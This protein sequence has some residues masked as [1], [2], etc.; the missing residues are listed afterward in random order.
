M[1]SSTANKPLRQYLISLIAVVNID[2]SKVT[3]ESQVKSGVDSTGVIPKNKSK[4]KLNKRLKKLSSQLSK[5]FNV[6][7][8]M[9]NQLSKLNKMANSGSKQQI[10]IR[11]MQAQIK[12][13]ETQLT[14]LN[15]EIAGF[16]T[17]SK[18]SGKTGNKKAKA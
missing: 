12:V 6:N 3:T 10:V 14:K 18:Q 16:K 2:M 8:K 1:I 7:K 15:G 9:Q 17:S 13:I 11:N 4:V 5:H